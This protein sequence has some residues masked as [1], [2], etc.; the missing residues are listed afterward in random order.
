M[1]LFFSVRTLSLGCIQGRESVQSS[2]RESVY[3]CNLEN[4][5]RQQCVQIEDCFINWKLFVF[6]LT[7]VLSLEF[8]S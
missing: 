1:G 6:D 4:L 7:L 8:F 5:I 3:I 2:D